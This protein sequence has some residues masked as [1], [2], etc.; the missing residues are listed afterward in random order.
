MDIEAVEVR[1][2]DG[3]PFLAIWKKDGTQA[4]R[5]LPAELNLDEK[6]SHAAD[7]V[8]KEEKVGQVRIFYSD[9]SL[10]RRL[11]AARE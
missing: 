5:E 6:Q 10:K 7:S 4:T 9:A 1:D 8:Y 2:Y 3:E 11:Q